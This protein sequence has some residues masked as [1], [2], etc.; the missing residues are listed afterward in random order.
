MADWTNLESSVPTKGLSQPESTGPPRATRI[1]RFD[2]G[3]YCAAGFGF[4]SLV[5]SAT[6]LK[7]DARLGSPAPLYIGIIGY[8][9]IGRCMAIPSWG[10]SLLYLV[11]ITALGATPRSTHWVSEVSRSYCAS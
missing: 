7:L 5:S 4:G 9:Q 3:P 10:V 6:H 2:H 11:A 8:E 1:P